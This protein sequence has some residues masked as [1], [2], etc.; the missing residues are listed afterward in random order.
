MVMLPVKLPVKMPV[1]MPGRRQGP[2]IQNRRMRSHPAACS[3][4]EKVSR[5]KLRH[6]AGIGSVLHA[7]RR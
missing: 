1:K 6:S 5:G 4:S 7:F 3:S 2:L